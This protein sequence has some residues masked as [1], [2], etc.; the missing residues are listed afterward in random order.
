MSANQSNDYEAG[1]SLEVL[2]TADGSIFYKIYNDS[3][4]ALTNGEGYFL[5]F[6]PT[7]TAGYYPT[8]AAWATTTAVR[9]K[10][11]V[12]NNAISGKA[13]IPAYSWGYVQYQGYCPK[14]IMTASIAAKVFLQGANAV[15][16]AVSDGAALTA[17]SFAITL[18][19]DAVAAAGYT[20]CL[21]LGRD[22]AIG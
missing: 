3:A 1:K 14:V 16:T 2:E 6:I 8:V 7:T 13:T 5:S 19:T 11:V 4:S 9:Q 17:D 20:D 18:T 22:A 12:V 15:S 10:V 21:L